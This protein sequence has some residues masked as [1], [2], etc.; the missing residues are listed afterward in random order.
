MKKTT[1]DLETPI[2]RELNEELGALP[3]IDVHDFDEHAFDFLREYDA[4][5]ER[6]QAEEAAEPVAAASGG[7]SG[8]SRRG[9][10]RRK[11]D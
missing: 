1:P 4:N 8:S 7:K 11:G 9:G 2:F 5:A 3:E 6:E 10:R